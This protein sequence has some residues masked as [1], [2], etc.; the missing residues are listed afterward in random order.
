MKVAIVDD[1]QNVANAART[2]QQPLVNTDRCR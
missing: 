2:G 1:H